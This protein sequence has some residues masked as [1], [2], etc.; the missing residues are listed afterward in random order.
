[1]RGESLTYESPPSNVVIL[2]TP[3]TYWATGIGEVDEIK[4]L[5]DYENPNSIYYDDGLRRELEKNPPPSTLNTILTNLITTKDATVDEYSNPFKNIDEIPRGGFKEPFFLD[6]TY[7]PPGVTRVLY[8]V[9]VNI[10]YCKPADSGPGCSKDCDGG[11]PGQET[12]PLNKAYGEFFLQ[13]D[14]RVPDEWY[15]PPYWGDAE[16]TLGT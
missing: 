14:I 11:C 16:R 8:W 12:P 1:M 13:A 2:R 9:K 4:K 15:Q 3:G 7:I 5:Y 10:V 6:V